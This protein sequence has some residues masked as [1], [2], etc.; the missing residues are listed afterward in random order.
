MQRRERERQR[1][2]ER[3]RLAREQR[4]KEASER[5]LKAEREETERKILAERERIKRLIKR[6]ERTGLDPDPE[7]QAELDSLLLPHE[8]EEREAKAAKA[9][10]RAAA[11]EAAKIKRAAAAV[12]TAPAAPV[13]VA[14]ASS[15][16]P[17][18]ATPKTPKT[19]A[20]HQRTRAIVGP[21]PIP[22]IKTA[23]PTSKD[24]PDAAAFMPNAD[25]LE[26][27]WFTSSMANAAAEAVRKGQFAT[28]IHWYADKEG[29]HRRKVRGEGSGGETTLQP[30][31]WSLMQPGPSRRR[32]RVCGIWQTSRAFRTLQ[33]RMTRRAATTRRRRHRGGAAVGGAA[34]VV[35]SATATER[36]CAELRRLPRRCP[37]PDCITTVRSPRRQCRVLCPALG[38]RLPPAP[39]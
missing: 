3:D 14:A 8:I 33:Q 4:K 11:R 35:P 28:P 2:A 30:P 17:A 27:V 34:A 1:E 23:N 39:L 20:V 22:V 16:A 12:A 10:A 29:H 15:A 37:R 31:H 26:S 7:L 9:A 32:W 38:C 5:R 21:R 6:R 18:A 36:A 19:P 24:V 25:A 13:V